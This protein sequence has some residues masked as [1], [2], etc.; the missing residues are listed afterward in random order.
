MNTIKTLFYSE[1]EY[2]EVMKTLKKV[3]P[4]IKCRFA[5]VGG[6]ANRCLF[7]EWAERQRG[8][9][10]ND[11]DLVLLPTK[12]E[13]GKDWLDSQ[14]K[15]KFYIGYF[16][17]NKDG[18][19][20]GSKDKENYLF[21]DFFSRLQNTALQTI[22]LDGV[23]YNTLSNEEIYLSNLKYV[24]EFIIR[25][26]VLHPKYFEF[27]KFMED[28]I[29]RDIIDSIWDRE[30]PII[31]FQ[32]PEYAFQTFDEYLAMIDK[33]KSDKKDLIYEKKSTDCVRNYDTSCSTAFG[34]GIDDEKTF[35]ESYT[36]KF[37]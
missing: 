26:K 30:F 3:A 25:D 9:R 8:K 2:A 23:E 37:I 11:L 33:L 36:K 6:I 16:Y 32:T 17:K 12:E 34:F 19:Y 7:P 35:H 28:K 15:Q 5:I 14:I 24:Y 13:F 20:I 27:I 22:K 29:D 18:L 21:I 10:L 1:H 4:F 31:R